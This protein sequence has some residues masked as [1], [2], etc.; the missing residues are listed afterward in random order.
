MSVLI[1]DYKMGNIGSVAK[2]VELCG[3][4]PLI[5]DSPH[6][7]EKATHIILPGVGAFQKGMESLKEQHWTEPLK[8]K[9]IEAKIP[10]LG[11]CLGMQILAD[12]SFEN[13]EHEGLGIISG[14]IEKLK[15]QT[16]DELVPHMGWNEIIIQKDS[17]LLKNVENKSD[18]YFVHSYHFLCENS[19]NVICK[20]PYCGEIV[21]M[22]QNDNVFG[23]QFHPE[24]SAK[25]GFQILENFLNL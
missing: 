9:I 19:E 22:I 18:V 15:P 21:S 16:R 25:T 12:K 4:K 11:I 3:K 24:K 1:I 10:F 5:S 17:P 14:T 8:E 6:L 20:T 23:M 7:L 2:A 13:G